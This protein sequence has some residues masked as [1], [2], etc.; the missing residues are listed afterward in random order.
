MIQVMAKRKGSDPQEVARV[1]GLLDEIVDG[2]FNGNETAAAKALDVTQATVNFVR[3]NKRAPGLDLLDGMAAVTGRAID[4][5]RGKRP[6]FCELPGWAEALPEAMRMF[7]QLPPAAFEAAGNLMGMAPPGEITPLVIGQIA[8]GWY[9]SADDATRI[10]AR[11][12]RTEA[13]LDVEMRASDN[14]SE[15]FRGRT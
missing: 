11:R 2:R 12:S 4:D 14:D 8:Q 10:A 6:R 15:L 7:K 13:A 3:N 1:R 5:I 9:A